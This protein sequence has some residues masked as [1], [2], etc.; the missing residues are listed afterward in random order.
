[1]IEGSASGSC[2][3]RMIFQGCAPKGIRGFNYFGIDLPDAQLSQAH[4]RGNREY[5]RGDQGW[6]CAHTE[7][8]D[9]RNQVHIVEYT[10]RAE[11]CAS[12]A[13]RSGRRVPAIQAGARRG[14]PQSFPHRSLVLRPAIVLAFESY[15]DCARSWPLVGW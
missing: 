13:P 3:S 1:M 4:A 14:P 9:R 15:I 6:N 8:E 10:A 5:G 2:T 12:R 11:R 7:E